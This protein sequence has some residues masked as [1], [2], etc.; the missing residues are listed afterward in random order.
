MDTLAVNPFKTQQF[1]LVF[2]TTVFTC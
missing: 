1:I 2:W